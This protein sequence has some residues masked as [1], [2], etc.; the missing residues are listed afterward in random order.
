MQDCYQQIFWR[1]LVLQRA[2]QKQK[3]KQHSKICATWDQRAHESDFKGVCKLTCVSVTRTAPSCSSWPLTS[4]DK[5]CVCTTGRGFWCLDVIEGGVFVMVTYLDQSPLILTFSHIHITDGFFFS[6]SLAFFCCPPKCWGTLVQ[7]LTEH[8]QKAPWLQAGRAVQRSAQAAHRPSG[9]VLH[10][11]RR[12]PLWSRSGVPEVGAAPH[13]QHPGGLSPP[14]S[15]RLLSDVGIQILMKSLF[16]QVHREAVHYNI[17]PLIK[18]LEETPPLFGELVGR[19]QFLAKVPHYKENIEVSCT[20]P[21][22]ILGFC[23][24]SLWTDVTAMRHHKNTMFSLTILMLRWL[25]L[26]ELCSLSRY[27]NLSWSK[28]SSAPNRVLLNWLG[29]FWFRMMMKQDLTGDWSHPCL[30]HL[31]LFSSGCFAGFP[32]LASS[33][34]SF[35]KH[36]T[37]QHNLCLRCDDHHADKCQENWFLP[38]VGL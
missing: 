6:F 3:L 1:S 20:Y 15:P 34:C 8:A 14:Q 26:P 19:Q 32:L 13:R 9:A 10:R 37:F 31:Q 18:R 33:I 21:P 24:A 25:Y 11:P 23:S 16:L 5:L 36:L 27:P 38:W 4:Q 12:F 17:K 35:Q 28:E 2:V 30:E 29:T 7:H 22:I